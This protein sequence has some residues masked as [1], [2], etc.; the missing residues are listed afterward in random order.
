MEMASAPRDAKLDTSVE[1]TENFRKFTRRFCAETAT[2][3]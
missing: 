2:R 3:D 1:Q